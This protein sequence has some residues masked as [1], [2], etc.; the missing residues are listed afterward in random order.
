VVCH[1]F[2]AGVIDNQGNVRPVEEWLR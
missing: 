1:L 2:A